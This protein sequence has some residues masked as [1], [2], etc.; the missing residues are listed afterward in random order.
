[1]LDSGQPFGRRYYWKSDFFSEM[2][3]RLIDAMVEHAERI[4]SAHS[5]ALFMHL[6]G[7]PAINGYAYAFRNG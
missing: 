2:S 6:G 3:E 5:A 7:A 4:T 1:M